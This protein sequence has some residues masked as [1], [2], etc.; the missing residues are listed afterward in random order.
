MA[1]PGSLSNHHLFTLPPLLLA[2]Y[3]MT[4]FGQ[5]YA[6]QVVANARHLARS[7]HGLKMKVEGAESGYTETHQVILNVKKHGGGG[8]IEVVLKENDIILNRNLLPKDP[9]K[10]VNH[11]SGLRIGV[12]EMTRFGM[13][14]A[15]MEEIARLIRECV[16]DGKK[17]KEEV[18]RLRSRFQVVQ[19]SF[20]RVAEPVA[21]TAATVPI[22]VDMAGY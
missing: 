19:Y 4:A 6:A 15:E 21:K 3:E 8:K 10:N 18:N 7:L 5:E 14:E 13:K 9:A 20:D 16:V 22:D 1:F 11:P 12:Q 17:V 2:T